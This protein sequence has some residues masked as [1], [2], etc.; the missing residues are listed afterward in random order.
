VR[1]FAHFHPFIIGFMLWLALAGSA[2]AARAPGISVDG[3]WCRMSEEK[4]HTGFVYMTLSF[5][6]PDGDALVGA[7][8]PLASK[9]ELLAPKTVKGREK[10]ERVLSIE[11]ESHAPTVLQPQGPHLILR[12]VRH[13]LAPGDHFVLTLDFAKAGKRDVTAKVV[14]HPP[15]IGLP[16]LPKGVTVD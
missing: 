5:A 16:E 14:T 9:V 2:A 1:R 7:E 6:G 11:L 3:V 13:K 15:H 12:G 10:L 8:T 4:A